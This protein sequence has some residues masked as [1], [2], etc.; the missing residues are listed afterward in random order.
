MRT[1]IEN[2]VKRLIKKHKTNNP[3]EIAA[4]EHI[5]VI[6]EPLGSINGYYNKFVRQKIIHINSNL[7]ECHFK[8]FFTCAHELGHAIIH[9]DANTPFLRNNT[10]F[11]VNKLEREANIFAALMTIPADT[12]FSYRIK[13]FTLQQISNAESI[14]LKALKLRLGI[15]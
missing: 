4:G 5:L 9:Q 10:Y 3:F 7:N 2:E 8:K 6:E 12:L 11:S 15:L 1:L 14:P 13:G